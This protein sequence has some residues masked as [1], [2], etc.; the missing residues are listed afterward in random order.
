MSMK[1]IIIPILI[2]FT[3]LLLV[4]CGN[5]DEVAN[6]IVHYYNEEWVPINDMKEK[7]M[8]DPLAEVARL[9]SENKE[10]EAAALV[11]DKVLPI[12]DEV[13]GRLEAVD[14]DNRKVKKM[15]DMQIKAEEFAR[16]MSKSIITYYEGGNVSEQDIE[17]YDEELQEKYQDVLDYRDKLMDKY[18]LEQTEN[19]DE[20]SKFY[21]LKRAED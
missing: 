18:N 17:E 12:V 6:E 8:R 19:E 3:L 2:V 9:E 7:E 10:D 21:K 14:T 5:K 16:N 13:L 15:N 11:K 1:K 4:S 20:D